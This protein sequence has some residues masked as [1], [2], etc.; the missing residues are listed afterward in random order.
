MGNGFQNNGTA[1][2]VDPNK[3]NIDTVDGRV[4]LQKELLSTYHHMSTEKLQIKQ[5]ESLKNGKMPDENDNKP[6]IKKIMHGKNY[7]ELQILQ[8]NGFLL[9]KESLYNLTQNFNKGDFD[10]A[11]TKIDLFESVNMVAAVKNAFQFVMDQGAKS[12][13]IIGND[14]LPEYI[15]DNIKLSE[16]MKNLVNNYY[17]MSDSGVLEALENIYS[18]L[19]RDNN[20]NNNDLFLKFVKGMIKIY[21]VCAAREA[22]DEIM[23]QY[24]TQIEN[25]MISTRKSQSAEVSGSA[26]LGATKL[27]VTSSLHKDE[28]SND[29]SFYTISV[30]G[31][32]RFNVGFDLL[33]SLAGE[34]GLGVDVTK[35]AVFFSLEQLL[36]S[37]KVKTNIL[38]AKDIRQTLKSRQ[39][40]QARERELLSIFG[41][42][43]EGYLKMIG[44]I[45]VS[46]YIE[47]PEL[48]RAAP[49]DEAI[50]VS[51]SVDATASAFE[52]L[53][54]TLVG[55]ADIK[56]WKRP[57]GYMTLVSE[58][59]SPTDGLTATD[60]VSFLG[61][62]YSI[63]ESLQRRL[64]AMKKGKKAR[65]VSNYSY[66][67]DFDA[68][69]F[70]QTQNLER[71]ITMILGDL[72]A[73]NAAL[74]VLAE[75][76]S[77]KRA[78]TKKH[79]IEQTWLPKHKF[80]SEGRLGVL[81]SMIAAA[82]MLHDTAIG[83]MSYK[84]DTGQMSYETDPKNDRQITGRE[85]ELFKQLNSEMSRLAQMLEFS[86]KRSHRSATFM[87]KTTAHNSA[88]QASASFSI[89]RYGDVEFSVNRSWVK[90][91][92]LQDENGD[93]MS[94]D[95]VLPITP[96]GI[97]GT[98]VVHRSLNE[99]RRL[100]GQSPTSGLGNSFDLTQDGFEVMRNVLAIPEVQ[101]INMAGALSG[102]AAISISMCR[103]DA[104]DSKSMENTRPLPGIGRVINKEKNEWM[105]WYVKGIAY[106]DSKLEAN[107]ADDIDSPTT[108]M[109]FSYSSEIGKEKIII[110]S[111]TFGYLTSR[112]DAFSLGLAD[113][114]NALSPWYAFKN[115][116]SN[117]LM[118]LFNNIG[119]EKSNIIFE[120]QGMY[121]S[122]MDNIKGDKKKVD[123]CNN[124][125]IN[126]IAVCK[127]L[128]NEKNA[129]Q[130]T[131]KSASALL[132]EVLK[133][134][135]DYNFK[136]N[137]DNAYSIKQK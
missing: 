29:S 43:I 117:E 10:H 26:P 96:V 12:N 136:V 90:D 137:Y 79:E 9:T 20:I 42:D 15:N 69:E 37:G 40:M 35:S 92:P 52:T 83:R 93:G 110:G 59:C 72:R 109:A 5:A 41:K 89:P 135:F 57:S 130:E 31:G 71:I 127:E 73:Y 14:M 36:D 95:I 85:L 22:A 58:N 102:K 98:G 49:A 61:E 1:P 65:D 28:G 87:A 50:T 100:L 75:N 67:Y 128:A 68:S 116:H 34:V 46:T 81:K 3:F 113:S 91:N 112:Y 78:E 97:V 30:G 106:L 88:I 131:V 55:N 24:R 86:K 44:V 62:Q 111:D 120:L 45:P 27:G 129:S 56:I 121:N 66:N 39:N 53:G 33:K 64:D 103:S 8:E 25:S 84:T 6:K 4:Q 13:F 38:S 16:K 108:E 80:S 23:R 21:Q 54:F 2:L 60:V 7:N 47:W 63:I 77:D 105:M 125:F 122:I 76:K 118:Q 133:M 123:K 115:A 74:N 11:V 101:D 94:V 99:Y 124:V 114:K 19:L 126:F 32:V 132:D 17:H 51:T 107:R 134:N 18:E 104:L 119:Y 48:T 82:V 70:L